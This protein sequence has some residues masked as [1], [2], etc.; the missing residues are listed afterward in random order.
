MVPMAAGCVQVAALLHCAALATPL[1]THS[2][3]LWRARL[4]GFPA[5]VDKRPFPWTGLGFRLLGRDA[6]DF[7]F[8]SE[9]IYLLFQDHLR[10]N[11]FNLVPEDD[12]AVEPEEA[13]DYEPVSAVKREAGGEEQEQDQYQGVRGMWGKRGPKMREIRRWGKRRQQLDTVQI[14]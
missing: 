11:Y 8:P 10:D 9:C 13:G 12:I 7:H 6:I 1:P 14:D 5:G 4:S 3:Q 2:D